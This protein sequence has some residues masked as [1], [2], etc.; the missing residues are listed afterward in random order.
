MTRT[1]H[2]PGKTKAGLE[3]DTTKAREQSDKTR[4]GE[5]LDKTVAGHATR[6]THGMGEEMQGTDKTRT[7]QGSNKTKA[8]HDKAVQGTNKT[9][10]IQ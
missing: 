5:D 1:S 10:T 4:A 2:W 8:G 3:S 7:G 6:W 9:M